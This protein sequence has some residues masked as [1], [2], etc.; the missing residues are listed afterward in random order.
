MSLDRKT[1]RIAQFAVPDHALDELE[2]R[3]VVKFFINDRVPCDCDCSSGIR[4]CPEFIDHI[5][6]LVDMNRLAFGD[7]PLSPV[8]EPAVVV[9]FKGCMRTM[10]QVSGVLFDE[11]LLEPGCGLTA[12]S[13]SGVSTCRAVSSNSTVASASSVLSTQPFSRIILITSSCAWPMLGA[14]II[15][16]LNAGQ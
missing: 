3:A 10:Q 1:T 8:K 4:G 7:K 6:D 13:A 12:G 16:I 14:L 11:L 2:T 5:R 15:L 9:V